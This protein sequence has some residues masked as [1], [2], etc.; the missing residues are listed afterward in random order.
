MRNA[1]TILSLSLVLKH[2]EKRENKICVANII[3]KCHIVVKFMVVITIFIVVTPCYDCYKHI[4][5]ATAI[6]IV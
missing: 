6:N 2:R 3:Y 1:I 5:I 4:M